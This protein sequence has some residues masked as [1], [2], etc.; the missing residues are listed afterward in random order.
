MMADQDIV[1]RTKMLPPPRRSSRQA[2]QNS[3]DTIK[4][5]PMS[6]VHHTKKVVSQTFINAQ[7]RVRWI[8]ASLSCGRNRSSRVKK[9]LAFGC[10][11]RLYNYLNKID[12]NTPNNC[13]NC[14]ITPHYEPD[15]F[16][17]IHNPTRITV[18]S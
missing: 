13:F 2:P 17:C 7:H 14:G 11:K 1:F 3:R 6:D 9:S 16:N 10:F 5:R 15:I 4:T 8:S 18:E 12:L